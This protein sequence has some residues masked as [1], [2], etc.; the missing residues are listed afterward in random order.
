LLQINDDRAAAA[1]AAL[2]LR[3]H[4]TRDARGTLGHSAQSSTPTTR[5]PVECGK[6]NRLRRRST[7]PALAGMD[8]NRAPASPPSAAPVRPCASASLRVRRA[9]GTTS[10]DTRSAK[11]WQGQAALRQ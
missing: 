1:S 10:C 9:K 3:G 5:G 4:S 7:V 2:P 6:G 11:V 8:S